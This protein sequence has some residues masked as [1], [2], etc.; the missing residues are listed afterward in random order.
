MHA[1]MAE[2]RCAIIEEKDGNN[3]AKPKI[4]QVG[5]EQ[6]EDIENINIQERMQ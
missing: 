2:G 4:R 3:T 6:I 1:N 5:E